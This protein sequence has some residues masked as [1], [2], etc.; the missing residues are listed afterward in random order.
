MKELIHKI[1][2]TELEIPNPVHGASGSQS[3]SSGYGDERSGGRTHAGID[4]AVA[5]GTPLIAPDNGKVIEA[6]FRE[7]GCG[8]RIKIDHG[9]YSTRYCHLQRIEVEVGEQIFKGERIGEVGGEPGTKGSGTSTSGC[10]LHMEVQQPIGTQV[11]P[12]S[13]VKLNSSP[14]R[15]KSEEIEKGIKD[16]NIKYLKC[17]LKNTKYGL[18]KLGDESDTDEFG[19][20]TEEAIKKL[21]EDLNIPITGKIDNTMIPLIKDK[22]QS[23]TK[24]QKTLIKNCINS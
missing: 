2:L 16:K 3:F 21:Q 5:C 17:F 1:L 8:G 11:N 7:D 4:I 19:P 13:I 15:S 12:E 24:A 9:G 22:V 20:K 23:L 10:H 18:G 14:K 6:E